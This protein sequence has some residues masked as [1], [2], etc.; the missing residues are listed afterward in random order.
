MVT[1]KFFVI[2]NIG[3]LFYHA[4]T[5]EIYEYVYKNVFQKEKV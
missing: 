3:Y 2:R 1:C 4:F 5:L